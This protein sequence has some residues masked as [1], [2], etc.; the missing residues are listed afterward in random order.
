MVPA[1]R[2]ALMVPTP[3]AAH[4]FHG[5]DV[6]RTDQTPLRGWGARWSSV[7]AGGDAGLSSRLWRAPQ[8]RA[9]PPLLPAP[10]P[11]VAVGL[12]PPATAGDTVLNMAGCRRWGARYTVAHLAALSRHIT[13]T[14]S[15]ILSFALIAPLRAF[16]IALKHL[17]A[18]S[19]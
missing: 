18:G 19:V 5:P 12:C 2:S 14:R 4:A 3:L 1:R 7:R 10:F 15:S 17:A 9:R 16:I 13:A 11:C 6:A 8:R